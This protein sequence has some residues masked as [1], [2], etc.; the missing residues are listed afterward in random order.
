LIAAIVMTEEKNCKV[1]ILLFDENPKRPFT[2]CPTT[3]FPSPGE[4]GLRGGSIG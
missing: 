2:G 3:A 4:S 1:Q